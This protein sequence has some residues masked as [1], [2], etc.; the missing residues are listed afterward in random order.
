MPRRSSVDS[1][2]EHLREDLLA[3]WRSRQYSV[4]QLTPLAGGKV[5]RSA[6]HRYLHAADEF[7]KEHRLLQDA[8][9]IWC[10]KS[11]DDPHSDVGR[12]CQEMLRVLAHS[13]IQRLHTEN[14][15]QAGLADVALLARA[16]KDIEF[17]GSA[18][19]AR[20]IKLH[21][22]IVARLDQKLEQARS[23]GIDPTVLERAKLLVRGALDDENDQPGD[24]SAN[25]S[26]SPNE[27]DEH[28]ALGSREYDPETESER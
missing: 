23:R 26:D 15:G 27:G 22:R 17:A 20:E 4:D 13:Q 7:Y 5:S 18:G 8:A 2:P 28:S 25:D 14:A 12:L 24:R 1:L 16:F 3:K 11:G 10:A 9:D 19:A 6:L 21:Q